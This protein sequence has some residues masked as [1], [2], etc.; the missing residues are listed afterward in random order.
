E[1]I[2]SELRIASEIQL[3]I[4]PKTFPP[5][6]GHTEFELFAS[7]TPA[8][9]VGGDFYDFF[10]CGPNCFCFLIGDVSGKGVP[11]A[12]Y[13]A[14]SRTLIKAVAESV[15]GAGKR[16][17]P[18][19]HSAQRGATPRES[20]RRIPNPGHILARANNGLAEDNE[21]CMFVTVFCAVLDFASGEVHYASAGHNPPVLLRA[22]AA[23]LYLPTHGDPVAGAMTGVEFA[24]DTLTLNPGD[25]LVL[26]TD[27]VTEAMNPA[28]ELYGEERLAQRLAE[29]GGLSVRETCQVLA[30]DV[31][32]FADG[33]EQSD[34]IT[35]LVLRYNGLEAGLDAG[36]GAASGSPGGNNGGETSDN[37]QDLT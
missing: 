8:R 4:L 27:G 13:M 17:E 1:R 7:L 16:R 12:F 24:T 31:H 32:A 23:P 25:A 30:E 6:P 29:M 22:N 3:G 20:Q 11:A 18:D 34:D 14:V 2:Q 35:M 21:S 5:L 19:R 10:P 15:A 26:Y 36:V 9:E 28:Q 33:A 37:N